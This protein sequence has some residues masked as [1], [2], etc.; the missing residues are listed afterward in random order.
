MP[1]IEYET[2]GAEAIDL[3]APMWEQ[4]NAYQAVCC[5]DFGD[6]FKG[7]TIDS[8]KKRWIASGANGLR[9]RLVKSDGVLVGYCLSFIDD[10]MNGT[11]ESLFVDDSMRG[12]GIG[13]ALAK[14]SLDWFASKGTKTENLE[15]TAGNDN[16]RA[17]YDKL[18]FRPFKT[19]M[20][21]KK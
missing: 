11:L 4:L 19:T 15:V 21:L 18:G 2:A 12:K 9:V 5:K 14:D 20:R 16:A 7:R 17:F 3:I 10:G 13:L 1:Q 8:R 6:A